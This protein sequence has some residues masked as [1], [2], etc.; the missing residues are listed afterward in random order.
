MNVV[1][2][3]WKWI[4]GHASYVAGALCCVSAYML[5]RRSS[6]GY[7]GDSAEDVIADSKERAG[8]TGEADRK[9]AES[10][11]QAEKRAGECQVAVG[12]IADRNKRASEQL[13]QALDIL[14]RAEKRS[15]C[16]KS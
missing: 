15:P 2:K 16:G 5:G 11:E 6:Y 13:D 4:K 3:I 14:E 1:K 10:V 9:A 8:R 12:E 7:R